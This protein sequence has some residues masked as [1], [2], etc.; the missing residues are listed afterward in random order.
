MWYLRSL[1]ISLR[2][3]LF[4]SWFIF[5]LAAAA[6]T[7]SNIFCHR[8]KVRAATKEVPERAF[9]NNSINILTGRHYSFWYTAS[10]AKRRWQLNRWHHKD[11]ITLGDTFSIAQQFLFATVDAYRFAIHFRHL[12]MQFEKKQNVKYCCIRCRVKSKTELSLLG[13]WL[14]G[15]KGRTCMGVR[16]VLSIFFPF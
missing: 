15:N 8:V 7:I 9:I 10:S 4:A 1:A 2:Q 3:T 14:G 16:T 6:T 5:V 11:I 12:I 13:N